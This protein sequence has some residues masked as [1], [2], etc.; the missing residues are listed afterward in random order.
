MDIKALEFFLK[1][2]IL[3]WLLKNVFGK[4]LDKKLSSKIEDEK[5]HKKEGRKL[6]DMIRNLITEA[7]SK[8]FKKKP[9]DYRH[10][11]HVVNQAKLIEPRAEAL[12][13]GYIT[14]WIFYSDNVDKEPTP[15][16]EKEHRKFLKDLRKEIE[17]ISENLFELMRELRK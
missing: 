11:I 6:A 5:Y 9:D 14:R 2:P 12:L 8:T 4:T 3:S 7:E 16:N 13:G 17:D 10:V 15:T 1:V